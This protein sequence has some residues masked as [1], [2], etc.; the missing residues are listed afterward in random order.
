MKIGRWF[1]GLMPVQ[2]V[3]LGFMAV[4]LI[5]GLL[6]TLPLAAQSGHSVGFLNALFTSTSAVCVTGLV[7][8][9]TGT[10][11]SLFGQIVVLILIQTGGLGFMTIATLFFMAV[12]K[13]INLRERMIIAESLNADSLSGLVRLVKTAATVAFSFEAVGACLLMIRFIPQLGVASGIYASIFHAVSAFCNA[14][15]DIMGNYTSLTGYIRDPL[16]NFTIMTLIIFGG[17]GFAVIHE[18][19]VRKRHQKLSLHAKIVVSMT[20]VLVVGGM[21]LFTFMEWSNPATI[22]NLSIGNKFMAGAFQSVTPR[23]AGFNTIDQASMYSGSKLLTMIL[24]F[25]GASPASTG[26]GIKTTTFFCILVITL[27]IIRGCKEANIGHRRLSQDIIRRVGAITVLA[28]GLVLVSTLLICMIQPEFS[29]DAVLFDTISAFGTVGLDYG[30]T[31]KLL[32]I[33][34]II[35]IILMYCGRVGPLTLSFALARKGQRDDC[36]RYPEGRIM[37]G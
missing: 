1:S 17:M 19:I 33:P 23:T 5:G 3:A 29:M 28:L 22:G 16:I 15:F 4:I 30:I 9:D 31:P 36:V 32:A 24:M 14:G 8:V 20:A 18:L 13:R 26:G 2:K 35:I 6:L 7:V 34:K 10:T 37:V 27:S 12:R 11:Y 21:L 25:I